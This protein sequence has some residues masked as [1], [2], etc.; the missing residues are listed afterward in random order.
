MVSQGTIASNIRAGRND[1]SDEALRQALYRACLLDEVDGMA[2]G[3]N[4]PLGERGVGLSGG[5]LQRLA[6]ARAIV[7]VPSLLLL[8]EATANLD[9]QTEKSILSRLPTTRMVSLMITHRVQT[10]LR[11]DKVLFVCNGRVAGYGSPR[12]LLSTNRRFVNFVKTA[13]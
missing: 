8:D 4:T 11:A 1:V 6:I 2:L 5:Q 7:G 10:V 9:I 12:H 13:D 3:I